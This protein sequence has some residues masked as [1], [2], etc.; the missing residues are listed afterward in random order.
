M[1]KKHLATA[2]KVVAFLVVWGLTLL[3]TSLPAFDQYIFLASNN[4]AMIRL[5]WELIPLLGILVVTGIFVWLVERNKVKVYLLRNL[6]K[7]TRLGTALGFIWLGGTVLTLSFL[8]SFQLGDRNEISYLPIWFLAVLLNIMMQEYLIRGYLFSL[9]REKYNV[10]V[11]VTVTTVFFVVMHSEAFEAGVVA[12]LNTITMS[13]FVS[14]LFIYTES[15]LAPIIT[16][17][18]WTGFGRLVFGGVSLAGGYP[19]IWSYVPTGDSLL[20]G[21]SAKFEGSIILL[22]MNGIFIISMVILL[23]LKGRAMKRSSKRRREVKTR[24]K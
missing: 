7:S 11:A 20:A 16:R 8:G 13:I 6:R 17:F 23:L 24:V 21:G 22:I 2:G 12:V 14:L 5:W 1:M 15:L 18:I 9:F 19:S 10:V 4:P 3:A